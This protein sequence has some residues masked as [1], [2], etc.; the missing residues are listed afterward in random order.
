MHGLKEEEARSRDWSK[1]ILSEE[2]REESEQLW[3]LYV[4]EGRT[5]DYK[6][7]NLFLINGKEKNITTSIRPI[8][9]DKEQRITGYIGVTT[10]TTASFRRNQELVN[11]LVRIGH[12]LKAPLGAIEHNHARLR[13]QLAHDPK[14]A[15]R[16]G[17]DCQERGRDEQDPETRPPHGT[18]ARAF[19]DRR[20]LPSSLPPILAE[21]FGCPGEGHA[22]R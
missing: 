22:H 17:S 9:D 19:R 21:R 6:E 7:E 11:E 2:K 16:R 15:R 14:A 20:I 4:Y 1:N 10:D 3:A 5:E 13:K 18:K 12:D 8:I